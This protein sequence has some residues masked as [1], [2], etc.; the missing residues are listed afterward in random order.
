MI[1]SE[2]ALWN[3]ALRQPKLDM[4]KYIKRK[5]SALRREAR[6]L[7]E[8]QKEI[9][10]NIAAIRKKYTKKKKKGDAL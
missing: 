8:R 5:L 6:K 10:K 7:A 3:E 4:P 1:K 2:E 9:K